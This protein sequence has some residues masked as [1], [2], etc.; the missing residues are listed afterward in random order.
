MGSLR[1]SKIYQKAIRNGM[2]KNHAWVIFEIEYIQRKPTSFVKP[3]TGKSVLHW[4]L[5]PIKEAPRR[6]MKVLYNPV[7]YD[8]FFLQLPTGADFSWHRWKS[9]MEIRI[10][11]CWMKAWE[12]RNT[13]IPI[14]SIFVLFRTLNENLNFFIILTY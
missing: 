1:N 11:L 3:K 5:S 14:G 2:K 9:H 8:M 4:S 13:L 7:V 10:L 6:R 12:I